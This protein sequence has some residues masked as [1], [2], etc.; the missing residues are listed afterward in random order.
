MNLSSVHLLDLPNEMLFNILKKLENVDVLY[1]FFGINNER[2][3]KIIEDEFFSNSLNIA[4]I[5]ENSTIIDSILDR[6]CDYILPRIYFNVKC[7]IVEPEFMERILL[8]TPY[9]NLT[10]LKLFNFQRDSSLHYFTDNSSLEHILKEQIIKLDLIHK[11]D[12]YEIISS[13][14]YTKTVYAH[15]LT[16]GEKLEHLNVTASS[17]FVYPSLSIRYLPSNTFSS[18]TLTYLCINVQTF[19]DFVCLLDGHLKQLSTLIVQFYQMD[20][21]SSVVHNLDDI[22][23]LKCFSLIHYGLIEECDNKIVSHLRRM[24]NLEKLTLY[25]RLVF[26]R[27]FID[28]I[29]LINEFSM[30]MS[31]L[32]SFKFYIS[33]KNNRNDLVRYLSN[34]D[35]KQNYV[36]IGYQEVSNI[37]Q[38]VANTVTYHVFTLPFQF[39]QL[40]YIG[41]IFPNILFTHVIDLCVHD[42]FPFEHEF[43]LRISKAFPKLKRFCVMNSRPLSYDV[44][45]LSDNTVQPYK[46]VEYPHLTFLDISWANGYYVEQFLNETKTHLPRLSKLRVRYEELRIIT[47]D[48]TRE[49]TRRNCANVTRLIIERTIVG[50]K[51]YYIYFPLL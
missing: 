30:H 20:T 47:K 23:N 44:E 24:I 38:F 29:Y 34:N 37:V 7:F 33:T 19:T 8:A 31:R 39:S 22:P 26:E 40:I 4:S 35:I 6:F 43:F 50:S 42:E 11:D 45:K 32:H 15:I 1:S 16:Y 48:F 13:K 12:G 14:V 27:I 10:E 5:T 28:P 51:D 2:L 17:N 36:N 49:I 9:P 3:E 41:N 25:L 21:D 46:I 18:S